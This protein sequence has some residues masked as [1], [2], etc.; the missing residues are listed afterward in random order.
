MKS[1]FILLIL[2]IVVSCTT[3][4]FAPNKSLSKNSTVI[5]LGEGCQS[6]Q[7]T[8]ALEGELSVAGFAAISS[9]YVST[10]F[11]IEEKNQNAASAGELDGDSGT[12]DVASESNSRQTSGYVTEAPAE[13]L[14]RF[15]SGCNVNGGIINVFGT[16]VDQST[17]SVIASIDHNGLSPTRSIADSIVS[18]MISHQAP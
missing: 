16:I 9:A 5:V 14:L 15:T 3:V 8:S 6:A 17:G 1:F 11:E 10:K 7:L 2:S 12:F 18:N 4:E 13:Y